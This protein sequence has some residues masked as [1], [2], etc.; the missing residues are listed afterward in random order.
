MSIY[1][2]TKKDYDSI[3]HF[4]AVQ[5]LR[6]NIV[7]DVQCMLTEEGRVADEMK[8]ERVEFFYHLECQKLK[9][10]FFKTHVDVSNLKMLI[11]NHFS[12]PKYLVDQPH[13]RPLFA[14]ESLIPVHSH[15]YVYDTELGVTLAYEFIFSSPRQD[16]QSTSPNVIVYN[17]VY[18]D[19]Y[20]SQLKKMKNIWK[21]VKTAYRQIEGCKFWGKSIADYR[22]LVSSQIWSDDKYETIE[23][24]RNLDPVVDADAKE[25]ANELSSKKK[26]AILGKLIDEKQRTPPSSKSRAKTKKQIA[27]DKFQKLKFMKRKQESAACLIQEAWRRMVRQRRTERFKLKEEKGRVA[28]AAIIIRR[29]QRYTRS[30]KLIVQNEVK[31]RE[32]IEKKKKDR[33]SLIEISRISYLQS[34]VK[35]IPI[36]FEGEL[37]SIQ[38]PKT[39]KMY[40]LYEE[41]PDKLVSK[42]VSGG[43][44][45]SVRS[46]LLSDCMLVAS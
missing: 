35:T 1:K 10:R 3:A 25:K 29:L 42:L 34:Q 44:Q 2:Y 17:L 31:R 32:E 7:S 37:I 41:D 33:D 30:K 45:L 27:H 26:K 40:A 13:L 28:A 11:N 21:L 9:F 39:S 36:F 4:L 43:D 22:K 18:D 15:N 5:A 14:K 20:T 46:L 8:M 23:L 12:N 16:E 24:D 6:Y 19:E 38:A